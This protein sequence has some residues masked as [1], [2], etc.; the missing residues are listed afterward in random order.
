MAGHDERQGC[1]TGASAAEMVVVD[2]EE[3]RGLPGRSR[4]TVPPRPWRW[5]M[6][7]APCTTPG[8]RSTSSRRTTISGAAR[9]P[10]SWDSPPGRAGI[11]RRRTGR[12]PSAWLACSGPGTSP[13]SLGCAIALA[14]IRIA[15]G[16]LHEAMRTYEQALQQA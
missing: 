3:F 16:R 8:G 6:W 15:Q 1:A 2:E 14:N 12:M 10:G 7:P 4:C 9:Q 11:S 5:A 13:T